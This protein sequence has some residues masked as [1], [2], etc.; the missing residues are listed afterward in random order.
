ML[1]RMGPFVL[2]AMLALVVSAA[3][4]EQAPGVTSTKIK[5]GN[6]APYSGPASSY[7]TIARSALA[8]FEMVNDKGG[9]HGRKVEVISLDDSFSPPKAVEQT[10]KLVEGEEVFAIFMPL[11]S[12]TSAATQSYLNGK[13][14]PQIFVTSG[15]D[16]WNQPEK[17]PWSIGWNLQYAAEGRIYAKYIL[18]NVKDPRIAV[19]Y[20]NDEF[21]KA[22]LSGLKEGL[23]GRVSAIADVVSYELTDTTVDSQVAKLKNSGATVFV[24]L[25][26]PKFAAQSIRAVDNL[27]WKPLFILPS[28]SNS[29]DP[30]LN[31]AGLERSVGVI[32]ASYAKQPSDPQW[33]DSPDFKAWSAFMD[34]YYPSGSKTDWLNA[35]GYGMAYAMHQALEMA[36]PQ[37]TRETLMNA[38]HSIRNMEVPMLLPGITISISRT[39]HAPIKSMQMLRF[40]GS[41]WETIGGL[42]S[43]KEASSN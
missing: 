9:I 12:P 27:A 11:G 39:D 30:V 20:Q 21:G 36:G 35:Y 34:K 24:S 28:V 33:R 29:I 16:R 25:T 19:L 42:L 41:A 38:L 40:N 43:G 7:G 3:A 14:V 10:R 37:L 2:G 32:S 22:V 23:G 17:Y 26:T 8:Y 31:G 5:L 6:T 13:K 15:A 1:R 18:D 4:E